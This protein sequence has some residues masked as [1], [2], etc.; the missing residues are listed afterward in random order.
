VI[1]ATR[2]AAWRSRSRSFRDPGHDIRPANRGTTVRDR[3][4]VATMERI[5]IQRKVSFRDDRDRYGVLS[6][7]PRD[8]DIV[9]AKL[10]LSRD[11]TNASSRIER[12]S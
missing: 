7:D 5:R 1:A 10:A 9:D 3:I 2:W 12:P 6:L 11:R 4:E 8:P